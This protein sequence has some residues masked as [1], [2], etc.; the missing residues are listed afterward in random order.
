[1]RGRLHQRH[2]PLAILQVPE[3][4]RTMRIS[5]AWTGRQDAS[6]LQAWMRA[7]LRSAMTGRPSSR[8][9]VR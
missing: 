9:L 2:L 5:M 8:W 3:P 6:P 4:L 1:M 7:Q